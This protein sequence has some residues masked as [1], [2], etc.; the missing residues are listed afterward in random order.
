MLMQ[1]RQELTVR[2][3]YLRFN[4]GARFGRQT[5]PSAWIILQPFCVLVSALL[6]SWTLSA[7]QVTGEHL[8]F[9]VSVPVG[10]A[11]T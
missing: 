8:P 10:S 7:A 4:S 6:E 5:K 9:Y 1:Q 11:A 3:W 2:S